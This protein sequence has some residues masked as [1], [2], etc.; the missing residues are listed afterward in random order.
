MGD[1]LSK[2]VSKV[3]E[4]KFK[5]MSLK[6]KR[7]CIFSMVRSLLKY[8]CPVCDPHRQGDIDKLNTIKKAAKRFFTTTTSV[9]QV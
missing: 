1:H 6:I 5:G 9:N 7:D 8:S 2:I 3:F 4:E